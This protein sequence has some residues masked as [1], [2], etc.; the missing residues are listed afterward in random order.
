VEAKKLSLDLADVIGA[1]CEQWQK[2][3]RSPDEP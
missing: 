2:P 1:V 3:D